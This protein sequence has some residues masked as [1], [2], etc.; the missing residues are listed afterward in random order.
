VED[1]PVIFGRDEKGRKI[2]QS[3]EDLPV[4]EGGGLEDREAKGVE[5]RPEKENQNNDQ[6]RGDQSIGKPSVLKD[7]S[8]HYELGR[9]RSSSPL[10]L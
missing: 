2:F 1:A 9:T 8:L 3:D 10:L 4:T 5:G 6:L 7:A